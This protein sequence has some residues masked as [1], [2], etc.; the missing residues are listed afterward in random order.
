MN[1]QTCRLG[2]PNDLRKQASEVEKIENTRDN[3]RN[4][5]LS[6]EYIDNPSSN[7]M[8]D[9]ADLLHGTCRV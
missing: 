5:G 8:V 9:H 1:K 4:L 6:T 2:I 7:E 3:K